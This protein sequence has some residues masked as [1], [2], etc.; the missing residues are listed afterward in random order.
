[1]KFDNFKTETTDFTGK[2]KEYYHVKDID[3]LDKIRNTE[4]DSKLDFY[5]SI[6]LVRTLPPDYLKMN[7]PQKDKLIITK[8]RL[9]DH[10]L[11]IDTK[12]TKREE[13]CYPFCDSVE[14]EK[15]F[16]FRM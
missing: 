16:I 9:G 12:P 11:N 13:R 7:I 3:K 8:F 6:G 5:T 1:M 2:L 4:I 14:N 15:H 10:I